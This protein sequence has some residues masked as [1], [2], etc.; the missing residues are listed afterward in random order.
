MPP[1][2]ISGT[3]RTL[4]RVFIAPTLRAPTSVPLLWAPA[5][6]APPSLQTRTVPHTTIRTKVYAKD[7]ARHALTDHFTIDRAIEASHINFVDEH[8]KFHPNV[9]LEDALQRVNKTTQ[10][11]VQ[12][13]PGT[14]D[15]FGNQDPNDLPTCRIMTKLALREQHGRKLDL[16]RRL[17]KGQGV[18][19][20]PKNLELNWAIAGG[21]LKHR[22]GRLREFLTEGKKVEVMFA[23]KKKGRK[24][25][26]QEANAVMQA[27]RGVVTECRGATEVKAEGE[28]GGIMMVTFEGRKL[29]D[30][31]KKKARDDSNAPQENSESSSQ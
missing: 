12:M 7:T 5:F 24:A 25:T 31:P 9:A 4:Y 3:S 18:G 17:A 21:D 27:V 20:A 13:T 16:E 10:H 6:A 14:V 19:P 8:G 1:T 26:E 29:E 2:H 15:E 23:P 22:L 30:K 28:V 11:L